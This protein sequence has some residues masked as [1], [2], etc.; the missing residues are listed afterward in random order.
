MTVCPPNYQK[1]PEKFKVNEVSDTSMFGKHLLKVL[2]KQKKVMRENPLRD[3]TKYDLLQ[4][5]ILDDDVDIEM[6]LDNLPDQSLRGSVYEAIWDVVIKLGALQTDFDLFY[7]VKGKIENIEGLTAIDNIEKYFKESKLISA[8]GAGVSDITLKQRSKS[9]VDKEW[10][11][12]KT[13][14]DSNED[15]F[16]LFSVKYF[17]RETDVTGY[18]IENIVLAMESNNKKR[19]QPCGYKIVL[20]VKNKH[21]LLKKLAKTHKSVG[22]DIYAIYDLSNLSEI[23]KR[24]RIQ[25]TTEPVLK[26]NHTVDRLNPRFHQLLFVNKTL[27]IIKDIQYNKREDKQILWGQIAR[28][29]KTFTAGLLVSKLNKDPSIKNILVITP[30]PSETKSQFKEELFDRY[31]KTDFQGFEI[32]Y[33]DKNYI[34]TKSQK[35]KLFPDKKN[36]LVAS[37]QFLQGTA[38]KENNEGD[39]DDNGKSLKMI[40]TIV[41]KKIKPLQIVDAID[42]IIFDEIHLGGTTDI[43]QIILDIIDPNKRAIKIFLTATYKKPVLAY[44]IQHLMTWNLDDIEL[45]KNINSAANFSALCEKYNEGHVLATLKEMQQL[46]NLDRSNLLEDIE[47]DYQKFP[48]VYTLTSIFNEKNVES[49]ISDN[50]NNY[51]FDINSLFMLQGSGEDMKFR[52]EQQIKNVLD[53][54]ANTK[55]NDSIF[56]RISRIKSAYGQQ[57]FGSHLWFC[58]FGRGQKIADVSKCLKDVLEKNPL[59]ANYEIKA[60]V[61]DEDKEYIRQEEVLALLSKKEKKGLIILV[62]KKFSLGVSLPCVDTVMFLNN[63]TEV[64]SIYQK[65]FRSLTESRGK[66]VGFVVDLNPFRTIS[67]ILDYTMVDPRSKQS[68]KSLKV[69]YRK[70]SKL[71][72]IDDDL[73]SFSKDEKNTYGG[74]YNK[75]E[76]LIDRHCD[77]KLNTEVQRQLKESCNFSNIDFQFSKMFLSKKPPKTQKREILVENKDNIGE[78]GQ[79]NVP[80]Q[81]NNGQN[82][83]QQVEP[84]KPAKPVS[85]KD[86]ENARKNFEIAFQDLVFM[87]AILLSGDEKAI[88]KNVDF[89]TILKRIIY[90]KDGKDKK[91]PT[92]DCT[93]GED[94]TIVNDLA[95]FNVIKTKLFP[96]LHQ[97]SNK[98][99]CTYM[100]QMLRELLTKIEINTLPKINS[101]FEAM[102]E[103]LTIDAK[104]VTKLKQMIENNL[105]PKEIEKAMYGEVFTPLSLVQEML[106]TIEKYADKNFWKN[107][108]MKIL[109]PAAGIGNFP[110][111]AFEKLMTGLESAIPSKS[112]RKKHILEKMLYMVELNP[113]NV[114]LMRKIFGG[115]KY[116]LNILTTSFL[117]EKQDEINKDTTLSKNQKKDGKQLLEWKAKMKFDLVMGNPP[118]QANQEAEGKRGGGDQIWDDFVHQCLNC[119]AKQGFLNLVHPSGWRKPESENSKYQGMFK[120]MTT[121]NQMHYLEIHDTSDGQKTFDSGTRY[122]WYVLQKMKAILKTVVKD[123]QGKVVRVN[124]TNMQWLPNFNLKEVLNLLAKP[125]DT[126]CNLLFHSTA[127]ETRKAW[128]KDDDWIVK[129]PDE[130]KGYMKVLIH[131]TPQKGVRYMWTNDF[132]KDK[133][134]GVPMF[135]VPK[136]IF[137]E[138]GIY[139]PIIDKSGNYGMTQGAMAINAKPSELERLAQYLVSKDF[140]DILDACQWSNF[141]I[142]W[143]LFTYFRD[144]FWKPSGKVH[145]AD[146]P[147]TIKRVARSA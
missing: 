64:D 82:V 94:V 17:S 37:K 40:R 44:N 104:D 22:Q 93:E 59:F 130:A 74:L 60:V 6:Y 34:D 72:H 23:V 96:Y 118:F 135:G 29:G 24:L 50:P 124:L 141:R 133:H 78:K 125:N 15:N 97:G 144:G 58:P 28:S 138:S 92:E 126:K 85:V 131:S 69:Q 12:Q 21:A 119:L 51:G 114:R 145:S 143:R 18:D 116:K 42:L 106:D 75:V 134:Y 48:T 62:G 140:K 57:E 77:T 10:A 31:S 123:E 117:L 41:E 100:R 91:E 127:Y 115:E 76:A 27:D 80:L 71:I 16:I 139:N 63:E 120:K 87:F 65:M 101:V 113:N 45:C 66:K 2:E 5:I 39:D 68:K 121:D 129:N 30:A 137:G 111:I 26:T 112:A 11:C 102:K 122:D 142:D 33:L 13:F 25:N 35:V 43:S 4:N 47:F 7:S 81:E 79:E 61:G 73:I 90:P 46:R 86:E 56:S 3:M 70:I 95:L 83:I 146:K 99:K 98:E 105:P 1:I 55:K 109:D 128:V 19:K 14:N 103:D 54:I 110:L 38:I 9:K 53:Y 89:S 88:Y 20:L 147:K 49:I 84:P 108:K 36:I 136:V 32:N 132:E 8:S 107:P 67:A 52:N